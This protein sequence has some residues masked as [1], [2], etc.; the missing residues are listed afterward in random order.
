MTSAKHTGIALTLLVLTVPASF[1]SAQQVDARQLIGVGVGIL[2]NVLA[3]PDPHARAVANP[4]QQGWNGQADPFFH[5]APQRAAW[6]EPNTKVQDL[7][8]R[9]GSS[10]LFRLD[11]P[12][13][14]RRLV[15]ETGNGRGDANL[16]VQH[17]RPPQP[18]RAEFSSADRGN[19][20]EITIDAPR[21]GTWFIL[22]HGYRAFRNVDL[23]TKVTLHRRRGRIDLVAPRRGETWLLGNQH[24]IAWRASRGV[25]RVQIQ[26]SLD[27]GRTWQRGGLPLSIDA[28]D[29]QYVVD[30]PAQQ[31]FL[32]NAARIR[33]LDVDNPA[34]HVTSE[35]FRIAAPHIPAP[36]PLPYP[37]HGH[38]QPRCPNGRGHD[39][40]NRCE[41][42]R[43]ER[44]LPDARVLRS[45]QTVRDLEGDEDDDRLFQIFV[46][47]GTRRLKVMSA[48]DEG[49]LALIVQALDQGGRHNRWRAGGHGTLHTLT[50]NNPRPGWYL[51]RL[52]ARD[53]YE[54]VQIAARTYRR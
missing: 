23:R 35:A 8:G 3:E 10:Q 21:A 16:F 41:A 17:E 6:L 34:T 11:L 38:A 45:G 40:C 26:Y 53:D 9:A 47:R 29:R 18:G 12:R 5:H 33:V 36:H 32:T 51:I 30:L 50:I 46:P 7:S 48:G 2:Q 27:N 13:G 43:H 1:V 24:V 37:G 42:T 52:K 25:Q 39:D 20:E 49:D 4:W 44:P 31:G 14:I 28:D 19:S 15:V 22:V 54:D